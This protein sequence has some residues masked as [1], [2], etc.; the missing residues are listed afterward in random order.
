MHSQRRNSMATLRQLKTFIA[1]VE[2][3]KMSEK[4]DMAEL[5]A[6]VKAGTTEDD[7]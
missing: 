5:P 3:K 6:E 1:V 4:S 7:G 2:Y